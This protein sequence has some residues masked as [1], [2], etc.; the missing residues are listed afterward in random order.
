[1][2]LWRLQQAGFQ[3]AFKILVPPV[4]QILISRLCYCE[5]SFTNITRSHSMSLMFGIQQDS[6]LSHLNSFNVETFLTCLRGG[7]YKIFSPEKDSIPH[8]CLG[9]R[10]TLT[11]MTIVSHQMMIAANAFQ[12]VRKLGFQDYQSLGDLGSGSLIHNES[13]QKETQLGCHDRFSL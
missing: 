3:D 10:E 6:S 11:A 13:I 7:R 4:A 8:G 2:D 1:M 9:N 5:G 12:S